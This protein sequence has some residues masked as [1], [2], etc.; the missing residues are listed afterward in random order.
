M[1]SAYV[2]FRKC[3]STQLGFDGPANIV[4]FNF[5]FFSKVFCY[6]IELAGIKCVYGCNFNMS[7]EWL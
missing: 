2:P 4:T 3:F 6:K 1:I 5:L 7:Y